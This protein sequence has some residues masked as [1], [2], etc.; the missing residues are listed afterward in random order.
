MIGLSPLYLVDVERQ[1]EPLADW[2]RKDFV[3][4]DEAAGVVSHVLDIEHIVQVAVLVADQVEH[5]VTVVLIG[6]DVVED[7]QGIAIETGGEGLP[8]LF[9]DEV[10]QGLGRR[11]KDHM[12][13]DD[14]SD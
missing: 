12:V 6:I 9:V 5:H 4:L 2:G 3:G 14:H 13:I 1:D 10:Q 8:C 7:H 11:E